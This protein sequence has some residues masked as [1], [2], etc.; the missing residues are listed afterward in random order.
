MVTRYSETDRSGLIV[1]A[2][3]VAALLMVLLFAGMARAQEPM[4]N[5]TALCWQQAPP[6]VTATSHEVPVTEWE[7]AYF[8]TGATAPFW[9]VAIAKADAQPD[10]EAP[11]DPTKKCVPMPHPPS[12]VTSAT[13]TLRAVGLDEK[14]AELRSGWSTATGPFSLRPLVPVA[15]VRP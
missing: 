5:P 6:V 8:A 7:A 9:N 13:A 3:L 11:T 12:F 4:V 1:G 14:G 15:T 10:P 2:C